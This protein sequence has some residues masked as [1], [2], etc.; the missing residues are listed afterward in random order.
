MNNELNISQGNDFF[1]DIELIDENGEPYLIG[2]GDKIIFAV[3]SA[4]ENEDDEDAFVFK[5][6]L[7]S[8]DE[9]DGKYP[10]DFPA[11][12]MDISPGRYWYGVSI[13]TKDGKLLSAVR[14]CEFNILGAVVRKGNID[15]D[16]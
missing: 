14:R 5:K 2:E 7:T 10:I 3:K 13:Y 16:Y 4:V 8:A 1:A 6:E 11:D 15:N 9:I 12:K